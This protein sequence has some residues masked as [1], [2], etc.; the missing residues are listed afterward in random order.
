MFN[1][2]T[3]RTGVL[4]C[5]EPRCGRVLRKHAPNEGFCVYGHGFFV[6]D[7]DNHQLVKARR[8]TKVTILTPSR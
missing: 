8:E 1:M 7:A 2:P 3:M 6:F 5:P 4:T